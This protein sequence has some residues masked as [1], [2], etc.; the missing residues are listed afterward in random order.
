MSLPINET[1][2]SSTQNWWQIQKG[3]LKDEIQ[4]AFL[5]I[6]LPALDA[7]NENR[8][9]IARRYFS[10]VEN[11]KLILPTWDGTDRHVFHLFVVRTADR[12]QLALFLKEQGIGTIIH[13]QI[14]PPKQEA[15]KQ[16]S[17]K[18]IIVPTD[19]SKVAHNAYLFARELAD[20]FQYKTMMLYYH[21]YIFE[22]HHCKIFLQR[23]YLSNP[24]LQHLQ[25]SHFFLLCSE[26]TK[27]LV[28]H[29]YT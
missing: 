15:L 13:Y 2:Q 20:F 28:C 25:I 11:S 21:F 7:D 5:R 1:V 27:F 18:T 23:L 16:Y 6:K 9:A 17:M 8:R 4:A 24:P 29:S 3:Y 14:Q 26:L 10:E 12:D 22:N 19:F